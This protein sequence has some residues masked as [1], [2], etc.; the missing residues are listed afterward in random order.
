MRNPIN[1]Q[2]M[3]AEKEILEQEI[4]AKQKKLKALNDK[5]KAQTA[6][7]EIDFTDH[8]L[9]RYLERKFDL[10][11]KQLK[12]SIL[13]TELQEQIQTL[14]GKGKFLCDDMTFVINENKIITVY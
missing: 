3:K 11:L 2:R 7:A 9:I 8:A 13:T 6:K 4:L 12:T 5:I 10:N 1:I 14:G